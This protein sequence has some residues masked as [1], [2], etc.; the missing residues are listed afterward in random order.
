MEAARSYDTLPYQS[1]FFAK[2]HPDSL[3]VLGK[4]HGMN[5]QSPGRCRVLELGCGNGSSLISHAYNLKDSEFVGVDISGRHIEQARA[6]AAELGLENLDF[7]QMDLLEMDP[8]EF[9]EFDYIVG[10]GLISWVPEQVAER[11][12]GLC[13]EMLAPE[14]VGYL[15]YNAYPGSYTRQLVREIVLYHTRGTDDP[16]EKVRESITFLS[17]LSE[18]IGS[19]GVYQEIIDS[20][21]TQFFKRDASVIYHDDLTEVYRPFYFR[22]FAEKLRENDLRFLC[23]SDLYAISHENL[24]PEIQ[25]FFKD[26][27]DVVEREQYVDFFYGRAFRQTLFC[28]GEIELERDPDPSAL[29]EFLIASPVRCISDEPELAV[30]KPEKFRDPNGFGLEIDH[31]PTKTAFAYLG[32]LWGRAVPFEELLARTRQTLE[33]AGYETEDWEKE[34]D[35]TRAIVLKLVRTSNLALNLH[36][37]QPEA[38]QEAGPRPRINPLAA[39]QIAQ[40][41]PCATT[42]LGINLGIDDEVSARLMKLLDG[43]RTA[44]ELLEE[45]RAHIDSENFQG[46]RDELPDDLEQWLGES[47]EDLRRLGLFVS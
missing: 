8:E 10:H 37:H 47:L 23:E 4:L 24:P 38:P 29:E 40:D 32:R 28:R 42:L 34:M 3:G 1:R 18:H 15:S 45:L 21:L 11:V 31:P 43:T 13:R 26:K 20:R 25:D 44:P 46:D 2:T 41:A 39:W 6:W 5:P 27:E 14:G 30:R 16:L 19:K 22:D 7:R 17:T 35:I 36:L 33:E 9:G 12:F